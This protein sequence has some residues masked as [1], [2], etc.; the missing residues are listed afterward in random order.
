MTQLT[1]ALG[2][3]A[4]TSMVVGTIIGASI[5]VQPSE[6]TRAVH[7]TLGV[8]LVWGLAG[9]LTLIGALVCAELAS[10]FP[11]TGGVYVFLRDATACAWPPSPSSVPLGVQQPRIRRGARLQTMVTM[12]KI[13]ACVTLV[14]AGFALAPAPSGASETAAGPLDP[15]ALVVGLIAGLFAFG[16]W[17]MVTYTAEETVAPERTIPRSLI[18]RKVVSIGRTSEASRALRTF[19]AQ[20]FWKLKRLFVNGITVIFQ[21]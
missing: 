3:P 13:A 21:L 17:H 18:W 14:I 15:S 16:G 5:F 10:A 4:A 19:S 8:A 1:R 11:R 12:A 6:I 20:V 2:L 9:G 7:S